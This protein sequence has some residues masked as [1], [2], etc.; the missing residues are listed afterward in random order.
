MK[1]RQTIAAG[2]LSMACSLVGGMVQAQPT[3]VVTLDAGKIQGV[4]QDN[5][6]VYKGIPFAAAPIGELRWRAPQPV[7]AWDGIRQVTQYGH[8]CMQKPFPSDAA[9][10]GTAPSE[11]CLVLN[12]WAPKQ[13]KKS[14]KP[15]MVW[16]YGGGFV[17]GGASPAVYDAS[18]FAE[19]G[20]VAVSF[21]Y[22]LGRFGFFA[23]PALTKQQRK[24]PEE[25]LGN[26]GFMDQIAALKW[27][28][29]NISKFGGDPKQVTLVGESAGGFSEH[30]LLTSPKAKGLFNQ[31]IIQ[32][33]LGRQWEHAKR[34]GVPL[35]DP[36][37]A[38]ATGVAFAK[39]WGIE[40]NNE[41][42]LKKLRSLSADQVVDDMNMMN[43]NTP[44]YAGPML[45]GRIM[46]KQPQEYYMS[47]KGLAMPIMVGANSFD[48]GFAPSVTSTQQ[49]LAIFGNANY[50]QALAAYK[51]SGV[52]QPQ[53]I[54]QA[55]ASDRLMVEPARFV[56]Q[57]VDKQGGDA[58]FYR[59]GYVADSLKSQW[60]GAY[61]ATDIPYTFNTV[62]AKYGDQ[63][64]HNDSAMAAL[65][66]QYWVN[67]IKRGDPNGEGIPAW[68]LYQ[69][70]GHE[71][72]MFSN[73]GV[74][75]SHTVS[76]PWTARLDMVAHLYDKP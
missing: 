58:Y 65:I 16:I 6:D 24:Y 36:D 68:D 25:A 50:H 75:Y 48:I 60:P 20:I 32:S 63:L 33:G 26:Y 31:A 69:D 27:V 2:V 49:A 71:M 76:D 46:V 10:L 47:G 3:K 1:M 62:K 22:R 19:Q 30:V 73:R 61:H 9:P 8:D 18:Q 5:I 44:T 59:F 52:T 11:D 13:D 53:E 7:P 51:Q 14:L 42:A 66:H 55:L 38:E 67:F 70:D 17:N 21:N 56:A 72:M 41:Q 15:V 39:Q 43:M 54:A 34:F 29:N 74:A 4:S 12:V 40:G 37:S 45:D 57:Q 64:T 23:H 35:S 28:K